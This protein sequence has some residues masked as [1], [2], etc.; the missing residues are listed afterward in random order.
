MDMLEH[1]GAA[2]GIDGGIYGATDIGTAQKIISIARYMLA[3]NGQTLPGIDGLSKAAQNKAGKY[4]RI[5]RRGGAVRVSF[6]EPACKAAK[7]YHG[8]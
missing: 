3:S 2:S 4:L 5:S 1:V 6:D 7:K 8:Y